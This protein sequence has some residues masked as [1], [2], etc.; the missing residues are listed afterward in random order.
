MGFLGRRGFAYDV[1]R[2]VAERAWMIQRRTAKFRNRAVDGERT[3][4]QWRSRQLGGC[5]QP[6][7]CEVALAHRLRPDTTW[8]VRALV[9]AL[10]DCV[11]VGQIGYQRQRQ[12]RLSSGS[13]TL[14]GDVDGEFLLFNLRLELVQDVAQR[15]DGGVVHHDE[16]GCQWDFLNVGSVSSAVLTPPL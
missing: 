8:H 2:D 11:A 12:D 1:C 13:S 15:R 5:T 6:D 14:K 3:F 7:R 4:H 10:H 16:H 9:D